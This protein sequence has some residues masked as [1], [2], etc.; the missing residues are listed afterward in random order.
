MVAWGRKPS[1]SKAEIVA[2]KLGLPVVRL[3]DGFLRSVEPGTEPPLSLVWDDQGIYY[4]A[5]QPCRL[6]A[7]LARPLGLDEKAR[8][9]DLIRRWRAGRVSKY[10]HARERNYQHLRPYVLVVD[11]TF[12]DASV[13]YG[14]AD[15]S[16]FDTMLK[17][18]LEKFPGHRIVLK[19]HPDVVA[20]RKL[21]YFSR[22]EERRV[23]KECRSRDTAWHETKK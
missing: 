9:R 5:S 18:A 23:G 14:H 4:D 13:K 20:G 10:N 11:Q 2:R 22:S 6:D 16:S 7:L 17:S 19:T 21:G 1:A 12:G 15:A 8:A 3:E